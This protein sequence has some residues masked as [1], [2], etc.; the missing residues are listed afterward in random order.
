MVLH[1]CLIFIIGAIN[2]L[3]TFDVLKIFTL[4]R[5]FS[6][7]GYIKVAGKKFFLIRFLII[8]LK[9]H[10]WYFNIGVV[11]LFTLS[12]DARNAKKFSTAPL[13][14]P[15]T[16]AGTN[17]DWQTFTS[18]PTGSLG[19]KIITKNTWT[20]KTTAA[21]SVRRCFGSITAWRNISFSS[22]TWRHHLRHLH[23]QLSQL[24]V[25]PPH[26]HVRHHRLRQLQVIRLR[27]CWALQRR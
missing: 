27:T 8:Y 24:P 21:I 22:T 14:W 12:I 17:R 2:K 13:I 16:D 15:R 10:F 5:F 18:K 11:W 20:V 4:K 23:R 9:C 6:L 19:K 3:N 26:P 7:V 1:L 25:K